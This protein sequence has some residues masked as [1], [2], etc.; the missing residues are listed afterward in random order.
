MF[1]GRFFKDWCLY[2]HTCTN[3]TEIYCFSVGFSCV[4][5][6]ISETYYELTWIGSD[7]VDYECALDIIKNT[8][9]PFAVTLLPIFASEV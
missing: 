5:Y 3:V 6:D 7:G 1:D 2:V 8:F 9:A 4:F